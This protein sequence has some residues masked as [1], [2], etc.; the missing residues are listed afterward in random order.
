MQASLKDMSTSRYDSRSFIICQRVL[1]KC[2]EIIFGDLPSPGVSPYS[3]L[4][5]S[6]N[7]RL[8]R[9]KIRPHAEPA[10]IGLGMVL[11]GA[12][13]MPVLTQIMGEVAI[14]QGRTDDDGND[15]R[16]LERDDEA[17]GVPISEPEANEETQDKDDQDSSTSKEDIPEFMST[18]TTTTSKGEAGAITRR[19]TI[20]AAQTVPALPLHLRLIRKSRASEDPLGQSDSEQ[21]STPFQSSPSI[22]TRMP[23]RSN[24]TS[25]A[26]SLLE[27]FDSASQMQLLRSHYCRSE[28]RLNAEHNVD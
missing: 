15:L 4:D 10:L 28:V 8:T 22:A 19:R 6:F 23:P 14:E 18:I 12:P 27:K 26:D 16:S 25:R 7:A 11:A 20:S 1:H 21:A 3:T 17:A 13:G 9:K 24:S 2:H 5:L